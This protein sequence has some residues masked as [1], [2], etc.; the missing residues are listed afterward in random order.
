MNGTVSRGTSSGE[1]PG[2][3][4]S[5]NRTGA[6]PIQRLAYNV[7]N[8]LGDTHRSFESSGVMDLSIPSVHDVILI[9]RYRDADQVG[10]AN[11]R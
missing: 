2:G 10:S 6:E 1:S 7:F 8:H 3:A 11:S 9:K 5:I 4:V